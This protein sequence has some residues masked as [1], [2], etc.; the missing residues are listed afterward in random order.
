MKLKR[1]IIPILISVIFANNTYESYGQSLWNVMKQS[2]EETANMWKEVGKEM[3]KNDAV[4]RKG[5]TV[6]LTGTAREAI[7]LK[8]ADGTS[9]IIKA[10]PYEF[11]V[12]KSLLLH[13]RGVM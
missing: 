4:K 11:K 8:F 13:Q 7:T 6:K 9:E 3:G 1:L 5:V 2:V 12:E 10:L